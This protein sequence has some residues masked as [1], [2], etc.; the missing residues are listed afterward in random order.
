MDCEDIMTE[1]LA[2]TILNIS[3]KHTF[4]MRKKA[5]FKMALRHHP[6][7][8]GGNKEQFQNVKAAYD[9]LNLKA[10]D[11][12]EEDEDLS[13]IDMLKQFVRFISPTTQWEDIFYK[14][15]FSE[16]AEKSIAGVEKISLKIFKALNVKK[17]LEVY[18]IIN[19]YS[20]ILNISDD[21]RKQIKEELS[22]KMNSNNIIILNPDIDDLLN[23]NIYKLE[24][25]DDI[26][27]IP[28]WHQKIYNKINDD[29]VVVMMLREPCCGPICD[30]VI[31]ENN[32]I[33]VTMDIELNE[34][35]VMSY[36]EFNLGNKVFKINSNQLTL[37]K[38]PQMIL[39]EKQGILRA[40][41]NDIY[42]SKKRGNVYVEVTLK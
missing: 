16:F 40:N 18:E 34:L 31:K 15:S 19:N 26:I 22:K 27:Y 9:F 14:T 4:E 33:Y 17:A 24:V 5:Y 10:M 30:F 8:P 42:N 20:N 39:F 38:E 11:P 12:R 35:F 2:C 29:D 6:D 32:D 7:K 37:T 21:L 28:L 3:I 23:D 25:D 13:Y 36:K 1:T 41:K